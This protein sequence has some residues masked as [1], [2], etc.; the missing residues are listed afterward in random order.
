MDMANLPYDFQVLYKALT[1]GSVQSSANSS[2]SSAF[3]HANSSAPLALPPALAALLP[4]LNTSAPITLTSAQKEVSE[5]I[6]GTSKM[7]F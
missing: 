5:R 4:D 6:K 7:G 1:S 2:D 3:S